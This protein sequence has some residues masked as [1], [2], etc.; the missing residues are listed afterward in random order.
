[1]RAGEECVQYVWREQFDFLAEPSGELFGVG[2]AP[3]LERRRAGPNG[4]EQQQ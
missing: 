2:S 4:R 1:M 3:V